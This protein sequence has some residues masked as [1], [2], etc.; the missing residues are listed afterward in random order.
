MLFRSMLVAVPAAA[1]IGVLAR[2]AIEQYMASPLYREAPP[3]VAVAE[4]LPAEEAR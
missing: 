2:F 1:S 3:A 4:V